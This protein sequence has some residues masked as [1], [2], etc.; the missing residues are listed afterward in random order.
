[1]FSTV[2]RTGTSSLKIPAHF[3]YR[4]S[5]AAAALTFGS[6]RASAQNTS[7]NTPSGWRRGTRPTPRSGTIGCHGW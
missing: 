2:A 5:S 3:L 6:V 1:M 7:G 4:L